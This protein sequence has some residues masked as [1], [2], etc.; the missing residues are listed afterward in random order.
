MNCTC[1]LIPQLCYTALPSVISGVTGSLMGNN[2]CPSYRRALSHVHKKV[3]LSTSLVVLN[4]N[5]GV[6][7]QT[8]NID[9]PR[10]SS[11]S[12]APLFFEGGRGRSYHISLIGL[13]KRKKRGEG[14]GEGEGR[15]GKKKRKGNVWKIWDAIRSREN[16]PE[17]PGWLVFFC[18]WLMVVWAMASLAVI[19][20]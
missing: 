14:E 7:Q 4:L 18:G 15:K 1:L 6:T 8:T 20:T 2:L 17:H 13:R 19:Y 12:P 3:F 11:V 5:V 16:L 9:L 10:L